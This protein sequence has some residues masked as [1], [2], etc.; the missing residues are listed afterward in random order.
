MQEHTCIELQ[1]TKI[2]ENDKWGPGGSRVATTLASGLLP[3]QRKSHAFAAKE[4]LVATPDC[5]STAG[6]GIALASAAA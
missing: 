2:V 3:Q 5:L 1:R 6:V 4:K